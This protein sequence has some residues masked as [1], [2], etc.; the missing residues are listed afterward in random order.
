MI[1]YRFVISL[2]LLSLP[3]LAFSQ[4][5]IYDNA[6]NLKVLPEN[7]S[8][9]TLRNT[10]KGFA[11]GTGF[12]CSACHVGEEGQP[13]ADYDFASDEKELKGKA[14]VML[15]MVNS[16]N[17]TLRADLGEA[18]TEVSCV[19]CHRGVNKPVLTSAV[20]AAAADENGIDGMT[21]KYTEL[22]ARYYGSHSY[23][24]TD[25]TLSEFAG[26]RV[27]AGHPD[28]AMAMLDLILKDNPDSF[29]AQFTYAEIYHRAGNAE[30][31]IERYQKAIEANP[32][33]SGFLQQRIDQ[34]KAPAKEN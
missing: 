14:R 19:T 33:A 28:Q 13:L 30:L 31:A 24:F 2:L 26:S 6:Q 7:T 16:I 9:D 34:L 17:S 27:A 4:V 11:L 18:G 20:L 22:R 32:N 23:D 25:M 10:M 15:K 8:S 21:A 5:N 29:M 3:V 1:N 12:R